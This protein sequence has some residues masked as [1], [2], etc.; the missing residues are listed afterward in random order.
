MSDH[1]SQLTRIDPEWL[2]T[3]EHQFL[4]CRPETGI[5]QERW[6]E[7][8][9]LFARNDI[10]QGIERD[11]ETGDAFIIVNSVGLLNR[12]HSNG[13]LY[14]GPGPKHRYPPCLS[15]QPSGEHPYKRGD[16]A[17]SFRKLA[18]RWYAYSEGPS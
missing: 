6:D 13:Y 15:S 2:M 17:F 4:K 12:G 9:R 7:Y 5:T 14:C 16:E 18:D 10:T 8:R 1:D 11:P 3:R